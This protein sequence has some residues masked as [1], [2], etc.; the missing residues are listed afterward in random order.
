MSTFHSQIAIIGG[1]ICGLWLLARLRHAGYDAILL[2]RDRVGGT[3]TLASQGMIHGGIKYALGGLTT[4]AS[5]TIAAMPARWRNCLAGNESPDLRGVHL[6][7]EDYYL[8]SDQRLSSKI[9]AFFGSKSIRGRVTPVAR[10]DYPDAF[11]NEAFRGALYRLEDIV[12]D[13]SA[14]VRKLADDHAAHIFQANPQVRFAPNANVEALE[15]DG[16]AL[17]AERYVFAAGA[18]NQALLPGAPIRMQRRPLKQVMIK[19]ASLTPMFA[20][21][22]SAL[23]GAKPRVTITTH[24]LGSGAPVWYLGGNLAES[25]VGRS[26]ADQIAFARRE[27]ETLMPWIDLRRSEWATLDIDRAEPA[28]PDHRRPD[29]PH[30]EQF[31]N[32]FVCWPTKLTLTPL[33]ADQVLAALPAPADAAR[34]PPN[35][36]HPAIAETPWEQ[37]FR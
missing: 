34:T 35:L 33:L 23:S 12:V 20:H 11:A 26:N 37:A 27:I 19:H 9:T 32:A 36:P 6:L 15:I 8:F 7:S 13:T 28:Q 29:S 25:G 24:R 22:V 18:G 10:K 21:A 2:E 17:T 3:Q 16:A 31:G 5:E 14:L 4:P 30:V 1:G